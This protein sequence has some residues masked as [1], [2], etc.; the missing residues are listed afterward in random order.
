M[1][2]SFASLKGD[3][4]FPFKA[5]NLFV[6]G[7]VAAGGT[8]KY[9]LIGLNPTE[10][11]ATTAEGGMY[12]DDDTHEVRV[13]NGSAW[14]PVA[15]NTTIYWNFLIKPFAT[16]TEYD[17][18]IAKRAFKVVSIDVVPSTV[19]GGALTATI[20]KA[21]GTAAPANGTTPLHTA[22]AIDLNATAYT[23]QSITLTNTVADLE[24]AAGDRLG[25]DSSGALTVGQAA[26]TIGI[27][28]V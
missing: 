2:L 13:Y 10:P 8:P 17:L 27:Q 23:M 28:Y 25:I 1:A 18:A 19:Q 6:D 11:P 12:Y 3:R 7:G 20:V 22:N 9:P 15:G 21:T 24:F 26:L 5:H 16:V 4:R 14:V